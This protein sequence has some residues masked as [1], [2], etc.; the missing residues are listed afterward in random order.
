[1]CPLI[2]FSSS[3]YYRSTT[4]QM[5]AVKAKSK[6]SADEKRDEEAYPRF[7]TPIH[8]YTHTRKQASCWSRGANKFAQIC[9][10][11]RWHRGN[12]SAREVSHSAGGQAGSVLSYSA[13]LYRSTLHQSLYSPE[14]CVRARVE[15]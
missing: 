6:N 13:Y 2:F 4:R 14:L 15:K 3:I 12:T 5:Y 11:G 10:K 1:M 8:M 9:M 7:G